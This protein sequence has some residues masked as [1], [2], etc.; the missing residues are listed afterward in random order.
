MNPETA[1]DPAI[2]DPDDPT[3]EADQVQRKETAPSDTT[4]KAPSPTPSVAPLAPLAPLTPT[5]NDVAISAAVHSAK[6]EAV[7]QAISIAEL[8]QL[9]GQS[10]RIATFLTQGLS[11]SQVR[12]TLLASRAQS[13]EITSLIAPDAAP[14]SA[15]AAGDAGALMAAVKKLTQKI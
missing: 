8:C 14:K 11:A 6:A 10:N 12:Q 15:G 1:N 4:V 13:E 5:V 9:A 2:A 7:A 3:A